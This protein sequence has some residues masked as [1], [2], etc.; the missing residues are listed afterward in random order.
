MHKKERT[1]IR[2]FTHFYGPKLIIQPNI[3]PNIEN[4]S[5]KTNKLHAHNAYFRLFLFVIM[6][7]TE[8]NNPTPTI[9]RKPSPINVS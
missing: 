1:Y 5:I 6:P 4:S 7:T 2:P 9:S 8:H 3:N